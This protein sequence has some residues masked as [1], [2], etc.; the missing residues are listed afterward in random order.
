MLKSTADT[1]K[2]LKVDCADILQ[3]AM[4][5]QIGLK[6]YLSVIPSV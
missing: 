5:S 6:V 4:R 3:N 1:I 2:T